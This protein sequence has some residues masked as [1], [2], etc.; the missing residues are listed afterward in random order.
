VSSPGPGT[1]TRGVPQPRGPLPSPAS[2]GPA[3]PSWRDRLPPR[4]VELARLPW[5]VAAGWSA[6]ALVLFA[7]Y[8]RLSWT[9]P[10]N[11]DGA[12]NAL[13][14]W[15][16]LH[17]NLLLHGWW[18]SDV[19]FYTTELPQYALLELVFGLTPG[20]VH[21]AGAMTYTLVLLLAALVGRGQARGAA[22]TA[23][24]V[25]AAGIMLAPELG[26]GAY[27][28]LLSPDHIGS[29]VP[30]LL[31]LLILDRAPGRWTGPAAV[32][33]LLTWALVADPVVAYTGVLPLAAVCA[34]RTYRAAIQQRRPWAAQWYMLSVGAA[35]LASVAAG[36][37]AGVVLQAMGGYQVAPLHPHFTTVAAL[38]QHLV[39]GVEAAALL[40][41]ADFFGRPV[42][43]AAGLAL[44]H[45]AGATLA[46]SAVW[47]GARRFLRLPDLVPAVL[48]AA[49]LIN[50]SGFL[51]GTLVFNVRSA[52]EM[53]A[54]LPF[55]A[56][57]AARLLGARLAAPGL[58]P[59]SLLIL[60]GYLASLAYAMAPPPQAADD[61]R[62]ADWLAARHLT[63][64]LAPYWQ[65]SGTTLASGG[66]VQVSPVCAS[67]GRFTADKWESRAAWY[68]PGQ[69]VADF[70]VIGGPAFC[71]DATAA[72]ARSAFGP[73]A[74]SYQIGP[75]TVL[76]WHRN[77]LTAVQ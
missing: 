66:R 13:Q 29:T 26:N 62:L 37:L 61:Q 22:G 54:V 73:P 6:A 33:I 28:L 9:V 19:S 48:V 31:M 14:A 50:A 74:H 17:G 68:D 70:L 2:P 5:R 56:A 4:R 3:R 25:V 39:I 76:V 57:L 42:G 59:L 36:W 49:V 12:S 20:V 7:C 67:G 27:V 60:A 53:A 65:A 52:R 43:L 44:V 34:A 71:N 72:Q 55:G 24:A 75:Y 77:L 1:V 16:M 69:R 63:S 30:V 11:S 18:L 41:G 51:F 45:L 35:A 32:G 38:P 58:R 21:I 23:R 10:V 40:F 8:L 47:A 15:D 64:G 46:A